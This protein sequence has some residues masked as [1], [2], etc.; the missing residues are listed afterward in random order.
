MGKYV[1]KEVFTAALVTAVLVIG[2]QAGGKY[3][4]DTWISPKLDKK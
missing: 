2:L 1:T 3:A 4:W